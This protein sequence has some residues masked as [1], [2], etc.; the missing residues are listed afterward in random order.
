MKNVTIPYFQHVIVSGIIALIGIWVTFISYTQQPSEAFLFPRL[1]SSIFAALAIWTFIK[2]LLKK[3]KIGNGMSYN[4]F[5]K[6]LPGLIVMITFIFFA[7]KAVGF[8]TSSSFTVFLIK[9]SVC[10]FAPTHHPS[11]ITI[12]GFFF[13]LNQYFFL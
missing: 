3:T 6:L 2:A 13:T 9:K 7:A 11:N 4:N 8:Y 10:G 12:S 5:L 1:I